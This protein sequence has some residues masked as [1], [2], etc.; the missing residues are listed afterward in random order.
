MPTRIPRVYEE[1]E[2]G[3]R[4]RVGYWFQYGEWDLRINCP[5]GEH[6][7]F[8][9]GISQCE[10]LPDGR[11]LLEPYRACRNC[12]LEDDLILDAP[13]KGEVIAA[14]NKMSWL[15]VLGPTIM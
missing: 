3:G 7:A 12:G 8:F 5:C 15:D 6:E 11:L 9:A 1:W 13:P 14:M 10:R 2:A 4:R